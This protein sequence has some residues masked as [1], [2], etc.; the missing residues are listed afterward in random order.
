MD[1]EDLKEGNH[2]CHLCGK[3][4]CGQRL[5]RVKCCKCARIFCLQQLHRKFNIVAS[6]DDPNF[7]CPRCNGKC[8]CVSNCQ[9][10]P[11]HV[12][13]KVFKVRQNKLNKAAAEN[14]IR[15]TTNYIVE[16]RQPIQEEPFFMPKMIQN[17]SISRFDLLSPP[18]SESQIMPSGKLYLL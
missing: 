18:W 15:E 2:T 17:S 5:G 10:P 14:P 7:V 3:I 9:L 12:H 6:A 16:N 4:Q 13:C 1:K 11:P 8:C